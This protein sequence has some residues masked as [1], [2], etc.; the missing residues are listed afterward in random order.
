MKIKLRILIIIMVIMLPCNNTVY[1]G[2]AIHLQ[3]NSRIQALK[4]AWKYRQILVQI[5]KAES[6]GVLDLQE[7]RSELLVYFEYLTLAITFLN[8]GELVGMVAEAKKIEG[9]SGERGRELYREKMREKASEMN[10][11][12]GSWTG[13][14]RNK[15]QRRLYY[16]KNF[17]LNDE[18]LKFAVFFTPGVCAEENIN[19]LLESF[20]KAYSMRERT[21][22]DNNDFQIDGLRQLVAV[23]IYESIYYDR[24]VQLKIG[25]ENVVLPE[26]LEIEL[27]NF[28]KDFELDLE[29]IRLIDISSHV[30]EEAHVHGVEVAEFEEGEISLYKI[31]DRL[32]Y[33]LVSALLDEHLI[34]LDCSVSHIPRVLGRKGNRYYYQLA[35][36]GEGFGRY[37]HC[38]QEGEVIDPYAGRRLNEYEM[39]GLF[40]RLL[41][42]AN[43]FDDPNDPGRASKNIIIDTSNITFRGMIDE[44][45]DPRTWKLIDFEGGITGRREEFVAYF[46]ENGEHLR[47]SLGAEKYQ[48]LVLAVKQM[49]LINENYRK[50]R[51]QRLFKDYQREKLAEIF[52]EQQLGRIKIL[53]NGAGVVGTRTVE[54][55]TALGFAVYVS[56]PDWNN[57]KWC[58]ERYNCKYIRS[59]NLEEEVKQQDFA[60]IIDASPDNQGKENWD[61]LYSQLSYLPKVIFQ[62]EENSNFTAMVAL[63]CPILREFGGVAITDYYQRSMDF[64]DTCDEYQLDHYNLFKDYL[65]SY[66]PD[67]ADSLDAF[68][69]Y[70]KGGDI[71][72]YHIHQAVLQC[73]AAGFTAEKIKEQIANSG[74]NFRILQIDEN[75]TRGIP[76]NEIIR[77]LQARY[78][79]EEKPLLIARISEG[80]KGAVVVEYAVPYRVN[81][82]PDNMLAV[83]NVIGLDDSMFLRKYQANIFKMKHRVEEF[84]YHSYIYLRPLRNIIVKAIN[85]GV[86]DWWR[87]GHINYKGEIVLSRHTGDIDWIADTMQEEGWA[88]PED[89]E[90]RRN[91]VREI[92]RQLFTK[93]V[94]VAEMKERLCRI[95]SLDNQ[96]GLISRLTQE[97]NDVAEGRL[98]ISQSL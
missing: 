48:L 38:D 43:D 62:G 42:V 31:Y 41:G 45:D 11:D 71:P 29:E 75:L 79:I 5:E 32:M 13:Y 53:V 70:R 57:I 80:E 54:A 39:L 9:Y 86:R 82:V 14:R 23:L 25:D 83:F 59:E 49:L 7:L 40:N 17:G 72:G 2:T 84:L 89:E 66:S 6:E 87:I 67:L 24:A 44:G 15:Y 1:S 69:S 95:I 10:L 88:L 61:D 19:L 78:Q 33:H 18:M 97:L 4:G 27:W 55:L 28:C 73:A 98:Q 64:D 74:N 8:D 51:F 90:E 3:P 35:E 22:V 85:S 26:E 92:I 21:Q 93:K 68:V 77:V 63:F 60:V 30:R 16:E 94:S 96:P 34:G 65:S 47:Q 81:V 91:I 58:V 20:I 37:I 36:G 76:F 56:D 46:A 12:I 52:E 50:Y